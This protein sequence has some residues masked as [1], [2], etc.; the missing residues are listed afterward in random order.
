MDDLTPP[1]T[2]EAPGE[3]RVLARKYRPQ[4]L[5][6]LKGQD[7]LVRT[8]RNAL[9]SGR[10]AHAFVLTGVR[11]VGK[12]TTAR[13]IAK[14]LNCIGP[15]GSGGPT[16][17][18]CGVCEPCRAIT[19]DRHVDVMEMDAASRTGVDDIREIIDGVRYKPVSAR[20]KV[21]IIDEVHMLSRNAFNALLKT[22]EEP[23]EH[24]KFIFAT[25]EI[26][27]VPITVLS[28]CQR[29]DLRRFDVSELMELFGTICGKEGVEADEEALALISRAAD[30]SARDGLSIL[31]QAMALSDGRIAAVQV[32]EMLGLAD[33]ALIF[34]LFEKVMGGKTADALADVRS[35]YASGADPVVMLQDLLD[36][37]HLI[38][39]LKTARESAL[40]G[41]SELERTRG[42]E[43]ADKLSL[44][45]LARTWQMLM[46]GLGEV[47][48]APSTLAA[49]EMVLIR[50][51][52]T[53]DLPPPGE[54]V[55]AIKSGK[56]DAAP[57]RQPAA[58]ENR[59][60]DPRPEPVAAMPAPRAE[61]E[62]PPPAPPPP[63]EPAAPQIPESFEG[64]VALFEEKREALLHALLSRSVRPVSAGAGHLELILDPG[65]PE[66]LAGQVAAKLKEW[67]GIHWIVEAS[68]AVPGDEEIHTLAERKANAE[69]AK[70]K[71]V[72]EH[73]VVAAVLEA[74]PE[75]TIE[76]IRPLVRET[77]DA[78]PEAAAYPDE[79]SQ[80]NEA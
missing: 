54:L 38:T 33:R 68:D 35:M 20:Y 39:R 32:Q 71:S 62:A 11:G 28:R 57:S 46:K 43:F 52:Y 19:E 51:A 9:A 41:A 69:A 64:V 47:Q 2:A 37:T 18:P 34:D 27:K 26:R 30:G 25:T 67:T 5:D 10:L 56:P 63:E 61:P 8:L 14:G 40:E 72:A 45:V 60:A 53:A 22:L 79:D 21:Y 31:D 48:N 70:R 65:A 16:V 13:I 44:P 15:D 59:V 74:F 3:Y 4:T 12:T 24:V 73:P 29:F 58:A 75:S 23:P 6:D 42:V 36:L 80:A 49:L 7:A 66:T 50:L 77:E 76:A 17:T 1:A 55:K 78:A